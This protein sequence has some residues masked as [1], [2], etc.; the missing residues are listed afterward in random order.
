MEKFVFEVKDNSNDVNFF[1]ALHDSNLSDRIGIDGNFLGI[2]IPLPSPSAKIS[3]SLAINP[4]PKRNGAN[5]LDYLHFSVM[6]NKD[7]RLPFMTAVNID[8]VNNELAVRHRKR[9]GDV[10]FK[11]SRIN[12]EYQFGND[13][14]LYSGFQRG[15]MVRYYDPAW[16]QNLEIKQKAMGDT[17]HYTNCCPQIKGLNTG[18]WLDLEDYSMARAIFQDSKITVYAGPVFNKAKQVGKLLV[19]INF[20]KIIIYRNG[21]KLEAIGFLLSHEF[22]YNKMIAEEL[23]VETAEDKYSDPTLTKNDINRLFND[24][25]LKRWVVKISLIEE[26]TGISFGL[27]DIDANKKEDKYFNIPVGGNL[28][29]VNEVRKIQKSMGL[30]NIKGFEQFTNDTEFI[31]N[32]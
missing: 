6:F 30:H 28:E 24:V 12:E 13:D 11:D 14:Y 2:S 8:G 5:F 19:P 10:W 27:N 15:H 17:F 3:A 26:K 22:V 23:L 9:S 18:D 25:N 20:W 16:G 21:D 1:E 29:L 32:I 7:K 4:Q 31:K